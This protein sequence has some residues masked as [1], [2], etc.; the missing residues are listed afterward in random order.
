MNLPQMWWH[1]H[2]N[3]TNESDSDDTVTK[4]AT[5]H[6]YN[7]LSAHS[8]TGVEAESVNKTD[9]KKRETYSL[10][11]ASS[12]F[13]QLKLQLLQLSKMGNSNDC[14]LIGRLLTVLIS[15]LKKFLSYSY[16]SYTGFYWF[17]KSK[18]SEKSTLSRGRSLNSNS[19]CTLNSK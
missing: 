2:T 5:E 14:I 17:W 4:Q 16:L 9:R 10:K 6:N 18:K 1:L 8:K 13:F 12:F 7:M 15:S 11:K 19:N 3:S